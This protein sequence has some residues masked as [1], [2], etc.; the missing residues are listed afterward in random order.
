MLN[1][2]YEQTDEMIFDR[3]NDTKIDAYSEFSVSISVGFLFDINEY[4]K[5]RN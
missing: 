4:H 2:K 5:K 3:N 1:I